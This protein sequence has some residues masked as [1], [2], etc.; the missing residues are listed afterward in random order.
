[1]SST[2]HP[3]DLFVKNKKQKNNDI[4]PHA[5]NIKNTEKA[6]FIIQQSTQSILCQYHLWRG[7]GGQLEQGRFLQMALGWC[8]YNIRKKVTK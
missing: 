4:L 5:V 3:D 6:D 7:E 2:G 1:M 8:A